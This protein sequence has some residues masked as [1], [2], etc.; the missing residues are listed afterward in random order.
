MLQSILLYSRGY[1]RHEH[2]D[3]FKIINMN[4]RLYDPAIGRFFSPDPVIQ[5][6]EATQTLNRYSYCQ[7]NP[8]NRVDLNGMKD[9]TWDDWVE[10][11]DGSVYWNDN[12]TSA[13]DKDLQKGE[14]Y[15]GKTYRRFEHI[16]ATTYNDVYYNPDETITSTLRQ[17]PDFDGVV[18]DNEAVDWYHYGGGNPLTVDISQFRFKSS[19][20]S[21]EDF[22]HRGRN[23]LSVNF[24]NAG[25]IHFFNSNILYR[26]ASDE[27]LSDAY[28]TIRLALVNV[29]TGEIR[30][31]T[32]PNGSFDTYDFSRFASIF[33]NSL[34]SNGNPK[35]FEFFG[36][37][38]GTIRLTAPIPFEIDYR[39]F[40]D[41]K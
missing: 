4:A 29:N 10:R 18:T 3:V 6:Y 36:K 38:T 35:P 1:D 28:G 26:P 39:P 31:V 16:L 15:R 25:D 37:G 40:Y 17:R 24:F 7:N 33:A 20:L 34:R 27:T 19:D 41:F 14:T 30:V 9:D 11:K 12:V 32:R 8:V 2:L 23:A 22:T 5:D 21:V 13:Y